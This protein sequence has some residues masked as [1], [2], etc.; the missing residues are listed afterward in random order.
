MNVLTQQTAGNRH[1]TMPQN[2]GIPGVRGSS[3]TGSTREQLLVLTR[4]RGAPGWRQQGRY[5]N[6]RDAQDT[7]GKSGGDSRE[8]EE[9]SSG[10]E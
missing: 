5:G 2:P 6:T 7:S 8:S 1:Q 9:V 3:S 4:G 10:E